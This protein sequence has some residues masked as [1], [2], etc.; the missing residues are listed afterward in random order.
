MNINKEIQGEE[1]LVENRQRLSAAVCN[2]GRQYNGADEDGEDFDFEAVEQ[3]LCSDDIC[4][5]PVKA[6]AVSDQSHISMLSSN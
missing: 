2:H 6:K 1:V 3:E 4:K 5:E